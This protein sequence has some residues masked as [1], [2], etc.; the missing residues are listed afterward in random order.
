MS[1]KPSGLITQNSFR[2]CMHLVDASEVGE[3]LS[4]KPEQKGTSVLHPPP[5]L[6]LEMHVHSI[7]ELHNAVGVSAPGRL[8]P[9]KAMPQKQ[10]ERDHRRDAF[11]PHPLYS[12]LIEDE[13]NTHGTT[14]GST[15]SKTM[16]ICERLL[17]LKWCRNQVYPS[18][19]FRVL[20]SQE[21]TKVK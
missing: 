5:K 4:Q 19:Q 10:F 12:P 8:S 2:F 16:N 13:E 21:P 11:I 1:L 20:K 9:L 3:F 6:S 18:V 14:W 17:T 15:F 7:F